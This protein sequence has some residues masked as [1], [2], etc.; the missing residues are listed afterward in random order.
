MDCSA[1]VVF[2]FC[3]SGI[4]LSWLF[5]KPAGLAAAYFPEA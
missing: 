5:L 4:F 1:L 3:I 2:V